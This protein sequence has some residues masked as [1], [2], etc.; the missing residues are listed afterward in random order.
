MFVSDITYLGTCE[1]FCY[2][3]LITDLYSRKIVGWDLSQSLAIEGCQR[4]LR[5]VLRGVENPETSIHHSDRG[6]QY[7]SNGYVDILGCRLSVRFLFLQEEHLQKKVFPCEF[8][9]RVADF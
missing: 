2:L 4:A 1:G 9:I 6:I 3:S 5:M 7:C 8:L